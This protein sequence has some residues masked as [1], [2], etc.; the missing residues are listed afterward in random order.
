VRGGFA[1]LYETLLQASTVQQIEN[2]A[3]FSAAA[4]TTSPTPFSKDSSPSLTLLNLRAAAQPSNSL[5]AIPLD[6]RNPYSMQF[7]FDVQQEL[8]QSWSSWV[9][10][11]PAACGSHSTTTSTRFRSIC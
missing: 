2:N 6:L 1:I 3:P 5:V 4:I 11:P 9:I 10:A 8:S 7:S